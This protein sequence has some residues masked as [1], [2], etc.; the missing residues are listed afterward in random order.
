MSSPRFGFAPA[1][2]NTSTVSLFKKKKHKQN[3]HTQK[4][5][6]KNS[7][8]H[9]TKRETPTSLLVEKQHQSCVCIYTY[10][11]IY[12]YIYIL[13]WGGEQRG[14]FFILRKHRSISYICAYTR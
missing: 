8:T 12:I 6:S 1:V 7:R 9:T 10:I 11:Y 14:I 4:L 3:L 2:S 5:H 13:V